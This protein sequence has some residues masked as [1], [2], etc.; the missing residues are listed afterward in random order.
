MHD[1]KQ[2]RDHPINEAESAMFC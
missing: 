1:L 2:V